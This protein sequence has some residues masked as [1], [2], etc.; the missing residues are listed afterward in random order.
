[1]KRLLVLALCV[2]SAAYAQTN[3][4]AKKLPAKLPAKKAAAAKPAATPA[5]ETMAPAANGETQTD[6]DDDDKSAT[7]VKGKRVGIDAKNTLR[8]NYGFK[9]W[10]KNA[11]KVDSASIL[12][13]EGTSGRLLQIHLVETEPDSSVFSGLYSINWQNMEKLQTEFYIPPSQ[14]ALD[15]VEGMR[16][17]NA[18][19][20]AGQLVR[21]P[22]I[23]R[24]SATGQQSIEIFDTKDQARL[25]MK[26]YRAEQQLQLQVQGK[27]FPSDQAIDTAANAEELK[28]KQA[29]VEHLANRVR[30]EQLEARRLTDLLGKFDKFT[31]EEKKANRDKAAQLAA[32]GT[33]LF[34]EGKYAEA[35]S[36]YDQAVELDP[37]NHAYY[38]FFGVALYQTENY[39]KAIVY[40]QLAD[41]PDVN[42]QERDYYVAMCLYKQKEYDGSIQALDKVAAKGDP[43]LAPS[44]HFYKG[45]IHYEQKKWDEAQTAFQKVLDISKDPKLDANAEQYLEIILRTRQFEAERQKKWQIT[46]TIGEQYDSNVTLISDSSADSGTATNFA[47]YRS[48]IMGGVRYRPVYDAQYEWATNL[49]V[50]YMY[51]LDSTFKADQSLRNTDPTMATLTLPWTYKGLVAGKGY[52]LDIT[53]GYE[54]IYM[55]VENN[56][57]KEIL[58]S[59]ILN[60]SNL[61]V[62]SER[63]F[64][65]FNL[66]TR[67]DTSK[68]TSSTGDND[69]SAIKVKLSN[70]NM[71]FMGEDKSKI[72]QTELG[73]T[74]NQAAGKNVQYNRLD[75]AVGLIKPFYWETTANVKLGYFLLNYPQ[76][77]NNRADNSY[78][79]T[80]GLSRKLTE[81]LNL[82]WTN[83][84]NMNNSNVD[85]N[86]YKK[87]TTMLTLSALW[88]F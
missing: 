28:A 82:G 37:Q 88:G 27:K 61:V 64:S 57:N 12:M 23:L 13:R 85:A 9:G 16:K 62:M 19:I 60:F 36:K 17:L 49:D 21:N 40:L 66:E 70:S 33:A 32:E 77:T 68:L 75:L 54:T 6:D 78:T 56:E 67:K 34:R 22:F 84:Y 73:Y 41:G 10:N 14:G 65:N 20:A 42:E 25:A 46:A 52:K 86:K 8:I 76:N 31:P 72:L 35:A 43:N 26:A 45:I 58:N 55:S 80:A 7:P 87:F 39:N 3:S 48:L 38:Y 63:V 18:Q 24:R 30:L 11:T 2:S 15:T 4:K 51:T 79:L 81:T 47:G 44:A 69:S 71:I 1:M 5:P 59:M 29:A 74:V 50:I 83:S 53:P